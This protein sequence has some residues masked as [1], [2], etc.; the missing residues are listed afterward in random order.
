MK[1]SEVQAMTNFYF[2][3]DGFKKL[4]KELREHNLEKDLLEVVVLLFV[5]LCCEGC[6]FVYIPLPSQ[7]E[8]RSYPRWGKDTQ[9]YK[10]ETKDET[11]DD[12]TR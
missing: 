2:Q 5:M 8:L 9:M 3:H 10:K 1:L 12:R 4:E 6:W 11:S 7:A